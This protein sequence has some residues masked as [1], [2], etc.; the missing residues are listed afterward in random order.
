MATIGIIII[1]SQGVILLI[2]AMVQISAVER[3]IKINI[4]F[5]STFTS[6]RFSSLGY[7]LGFCRILNHTAIVSR[8]KDIKKKPIPQGIICIQGI[9]I[10]VVT[11]KIEAQAGDQKPEVQ[12]PLSNDA[13]KVSSAPYSFALFLN[14]SKTKVT[15]P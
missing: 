11:T 6:S 7:L 9:F 4:F 12:Y 5:Q 2:T 8:A 1:K 14:N 3:P 10:C 13:I 15:A